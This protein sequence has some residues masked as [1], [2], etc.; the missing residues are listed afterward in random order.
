[1]TLAPDTPAVIVVPRLLSILHVAQLLDCSTR[2]VR[3]RIADGDLPAVIEHE[4]MMVRADDLRTY[5]DGLER[6]GRK[7]RRRPPVRR[8]Y[9]F[10][11]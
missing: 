8:S 2:T 7:R 5:I 9:E 11:R 10:L 1:V 3:R 6:V 4:R